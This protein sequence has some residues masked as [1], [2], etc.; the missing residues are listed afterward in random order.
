MSEAPQADLP[1]YSGTK[2]DSHLDAVQEME[3]VLNN[4]ESL[5][6]SEPLDPEGTAT[7]P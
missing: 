5:T 3:K 1:V 2:S 6:M 7:S 4:L